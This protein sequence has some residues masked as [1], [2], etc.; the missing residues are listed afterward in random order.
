HSIH[1]KTIA[2]HT[3]E[4]QVTQ[5]TLPLRTLPPKFT[6]NEQALELNA[7]TTLPKSKIFA[8]LE[9]DLQSK[10]QPVTPSIASPLE[11][12]VSTHSIHTKTIASHTAEPQ[13]TQMTLPLRTLPPKF[14]TNEQA[15]ELNAQ[16]TLPKSKIFAT[17]EDDLQ[18]KAQPVTPSIAS[19]LEPVVSTHSIHT[20]TIASHTAEP[21]ITQ[22]TLPLRTLPPKF[23]TNEQ[24]LELN[25]QTTL[26]KSKIFATLEDDLQSKA[27]PVTPSIASPLEPVVSTHSIHTKTIA[28]HTAEPQITQMTLPLRTLPPK[29]T[30]NEQAL[31]LNATTTLPK[32]K[33]FAT[34]EDDLQ[35]KAQPVTPSIASPLEPVVSTHSIHTK[36]IASHTAEPQFTQMTLPLRTLPPK[37]TTN[38]QALELNAQTTLPKSKIFATLEDDLQSKAQPVTPS[39]ASPLEPVVSTHSI[40]TKTIA[41]HTAEPQITQMTLPL[42]TLPPKFTTNEQAL[43]LNATT[44]LPK[45]KIFATSEDDLQ[46]KAQPVT[47]SIAS[48]LEPVV[49]THSIHTKTIASHTAEPQFTQMTLPLRTLPP[50]FTTNEQALELNAQTTLPK[51]K[52][53]ATLEDD[54]QSKAQPVTPSIASPLEPVVST[55]SI[56]TKTIASHTAEPQVTQMTL[57]LR[58]L[59]PKLTTNEQ[60]L[61]LN[62][63]TSL[64]KSKIFATLEDDLQSK[65]QPVTPSI[66]S[67]L[68][69]VVS[70]HSIHTKTIASH[71]AEPQVTQMTLPLR[72]LPPKLTTNEQALELNAQTTLPKSKIFATLE[73][74]LQSK[75]QPVT[76]SIA[77]PLEPVVSTHSIH[78]KTIASHT[79]EPQITQMTLPLRTLPPKFT[80][81]EK[82]LELNAQTTLPKSK[83][84]ATLE[85]DLQSK[86]QPVTPSIASPLEPVVST[87]SIHT[88]TIASHTADPQITQI[89]LPLR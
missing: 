75:A 47:P 14:T 36:T 51:S 2:S 43:E 12:V 45:P 62:A 87:H 52:I 6:T 15:L 84:F 20:K 29:F 8:T 80:T 74:D 34:S 61:E 71:T 70:T 16:T 5:M 23:T 72:T 81:N 39:I 24:A 41:S 57:P 79:A 27:Q 56:H 1:T 78:T 82:P 89:T 13:I 35:S 59:P 76:P 9:D 26:P 11:P 10:A 66:A 44:T 53:F 55:H 22:M 21:Q 83:I 85:D 19:P 40:H 48:P 3:A 38:E 65:A 37:F 49:S 86:A 54:L 69:P 88:K 17:L 33:I 25:A 31:E 50:K 73:D 28:S 30:T 68:E 32:P 46:S 67:P 60:A 4:P 77:S 64:P 7:Q 63:Q 18:S 42:R 58:T